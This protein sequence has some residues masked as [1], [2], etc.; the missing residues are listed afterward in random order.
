MKRRGAYWLLVASLAVAVTLPPD[1]SQAQDVDGTGAAIASTLDPMED[2]RIEERLQATFIRIDAL[3][4]VEVGVAAGVVTLTGTVLDADA[5]ELAIGLSEQ[6]EGVAAVDDRIEETRSLSRRA[7]ALGDQVIDLGWWLV[8]SLPLFGFAVVIIAL[9]AALA[10]VIGRS[11]LGFGWLGDNVFLQRIARQ[12][13]RMVVLA[14]GI[15]IALELL[16][17]TA[18]VGA[19]LGA[20]G[21][22]GVALGFAF[23]DL[24]ENYIAS[25]LLSL[26]QPFLPGDHIIVAGHEGKV[27]R[28]TS[29]ATVL[30]T[31]DGNHVR[32]PN[33]IVFKQA[34][35]NFT[36]LPER[37]FRFDVGVGVDEPLSKVQRLA[38]EALASMTGVLY[39]PVPAVLVK[40]LGDSSVV[41]EVQGWVDQ[42][43]HD[44]ARVRSEAIRLVKAA[45]DDAGV[46]MPEPIQRMRVEPPPERRKP[47]GVPEEEEAPASSDIA[48]DTHLDENIAAERAREEIDL[49]DAETPVE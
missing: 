26:R 41:V 5:R 10:G 27:V 20:A 19:L 3:A 35:V 29:R 46:E 48:P 37:R 30:L 9:A 12:L 15:L 36:R 7:A 43:H 22:F 47:R 6:V 11:A 39:D 32:I 18:L 24:V 42:R 14:V 34:L 23:Q 21:I 8:N 25:V 45:L 40:A 13:L 44:F 28:L 4:G 38:N 31:F 49:L 17:A 33:A 16:D 1:G 2:A